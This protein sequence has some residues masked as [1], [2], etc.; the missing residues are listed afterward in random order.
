MDR[1]ELGREVR[2]ISAEKQ[3]IKTLQ[4]CPECGAG[5]YTR[6]AVRGDPG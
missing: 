6:H 3:A 4:H 5:R 1:F 2:S